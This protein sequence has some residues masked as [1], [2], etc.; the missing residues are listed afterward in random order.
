MQIAGK[1]LTYNFHCNVPWWC[2]LLI[3]LVARRLGRRRRRRR[4]IARLQSAFTAD[5]IFPELN[6]SSFFLLLLL[7][8]QW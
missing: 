8:R 6:P 5:Q 4:K 1:L 3:Q 2:H 7:F